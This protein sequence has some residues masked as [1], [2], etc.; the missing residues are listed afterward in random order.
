MPSQWQSQLPRRSPE[1]MRPPENGWHCKWVSVPVRAKCNWRCFGAQLSGSCLT[2]SHRHKSQSSDSADSNSS[3]TFLLTQCGNRKWHLLPFYPRRQ[4]QLAFAANLHA[5]IATSQPDQFV[6]PIL[7]FSV[8]AFV[9]RITHIE[10]ICQLNEIYRMKGVNLHLHN[11]R[12]VCTAQWT[13]FYLTT[14]RTIV[15]FAITNAISQF[16]HLKIIRQML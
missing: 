15:D 9:S 3:S 4:N 6:L 14:I 5:T 7:P 12:K 10:H 16:L 8:L 1:P 13:R 2:A 11:W